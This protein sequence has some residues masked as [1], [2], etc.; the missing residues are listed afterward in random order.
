MFNVS[1]E[2]SYENKRFS[3][4][5]HRKLVL[6]YAEFSG[7]T[8]LDCDISESKFVKCVFENCTFKECNLSLSEFPET[9]MTD[10]GFISCKLA[11]IDWALLSTEMGFELSC[12]DCDLSYSTFVEVDLS[13]STFTDCVM[14]EIDFTQSSMKKALF[15]GSDLERTLFD[16][17]DLREANFR[18]ARNYV[19]DPSKNRCTKAKFDHVEVLNLLKPFGIVVGD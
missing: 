2:N 19:F 8:F 17:T 11:G 9:R 4:S 3:G 12:E 15:K 13:G 10:C 16:R 18:Q 5:E 14:H 1:S 6:E 7:C